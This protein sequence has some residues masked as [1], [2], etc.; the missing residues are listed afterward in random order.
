[1]ID[2]IGLAVLGLYV[3]MGARRGAV[4]S[5]MRIAWPLVAY[6]TAFVGASLAGGL[7]AR[8]FDLP[9]LLGLA[10]AGAIFFVLGL[11]GAGVGVW[12]IKRRLGD[13]LASWP[14]GSGLDR[15]GGGLMGVAHGA[16]ILLLLGVLVS[17][18]DALRVSGAAEWLQSMPQTDSS[19]LV[20]TSQAAVERA[21]PVALGGSGPST[22]MATAFLARPADTAERLQKLLDHPR[23][24]SLQRD[25]HFWFYLEHNGVDRAVN[26]T[27]FLSIAY[28][29]GLR[30]ELAELGVVSD[31]AK[32]DPREFRHS[33]KEALEEIGP[34]IRQLKNDPAFEN[35]ARDPEIRRALASHDTLQLLRHPEFRAL[36]NRVLNINR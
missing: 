5:A 25:Q 9:R 1:M 29:E 24:R 34:R 21:V 17:F 27:S 36:A 28:D 31:G 15:I 35:L 3:L 22:R 23:I 14:R 16:V 12:L 7:M 2:A 11:I 13:R 18:L 6:G 32:S 4:A 33:A 30:T 20:A 19:K 8:W 10:L 26:R